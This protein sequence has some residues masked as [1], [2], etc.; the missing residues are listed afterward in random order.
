MRRTRQLLSVARNK[1]HKARS[2]M[3]PVFPLVVVATIS[4]P[5]FQKVA[6]M[7]SST[8]AGPHKYDIWAMYD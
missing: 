2:R 6:G 1:C 3:P 8:K 7:K 5:Q 4:E